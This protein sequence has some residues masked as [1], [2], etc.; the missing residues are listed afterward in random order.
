G[1]DIDS[2]SIRATNE[3]AEVNG[4]SDKIE[5]RLGSLNV[6]NA[7]TPTPPHFA[8]VVANILAIVIVKLLGEGLTQTLAPNGTLIVSGILAEQADKVVAALNSAGLN[9]IDK[10]QSGDWVAMA[11]RRNDGL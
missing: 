6:I 7:H 2:E 1:V 10:R 9:V 5:T 4:E 11:A 3:N 8:V